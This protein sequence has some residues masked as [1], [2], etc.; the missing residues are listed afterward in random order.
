MLKRIV[1]WKAH[2]RMNAY[3]RLHDWTQALAE[4]KRIGDREAAQV[5]ALARAAQIMRDLEA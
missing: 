1:H 5:F 3:A 4:A 2:R